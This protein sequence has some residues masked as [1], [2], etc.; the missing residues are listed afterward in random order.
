VDFVSIQ[1]SIGYEAP[2]V[3]L[4]MPGATTVRY[5]AKRAAGEFGLDPDEM[6]YG[7]LGDSESLDQTA[8]I[9]EHTGERLTLVV[10]P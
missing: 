6:E 3:T 1:V 4:D 5:A 9:A 10:V 7:L 8:L 2:T